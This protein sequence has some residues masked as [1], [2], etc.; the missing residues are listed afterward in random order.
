MGTLQKQY[1]LDKRGDD[2]PVMNVDDLLHVLHYHWTRSAQFFRVERERV[3]LALAILFF[4]Y[5]SA[6]PGTIVESSGYKGTN[7]SLTYRDIELFL[8]RDPQDSV[9]NVLLMIV[10]LRL[11]KGRRDEDVA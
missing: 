7:E 2:K 9:R 8:V 11:M 6:R 1:N 10:R 3:Q 4:V 5:T